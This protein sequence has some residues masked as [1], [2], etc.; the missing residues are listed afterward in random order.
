MR[1][2]QINTEA[3]AGSVGKIAE[4]I[5]KSLLANGDES[6]IAY[7]REARSSKSILIKIGNNL[8]PY[9]HGAYNLLTDKHGF[10]SVSATKKFIKAIG[11]INPDL[12]LLHNLHGYYLNIEI[13]FEYFSIVKKPIV[14]TFHDCWP[15]T[16]HCTHFENINCFKWRTHCESCPKINHY[17][18]SYV[19]NSRFNFSQKKRLFTSLS[20]LTIVTPSNW[21][22]NYTIQSFFKEFVVKT[23]HNGI[24]IDLF[25]PIKQK[26]EKPYVLFVSNRWIY[27]KGYDDIFKLRALIDNEIDFV[28]VGMNA[29]Q[30]KSL[31]AGIKGYKRTRDLNQLVQLY[32]N[33]LCL[34]NPT[35]SDNFPTVNL[36]AL[37]CGTPVITYNT[38]GSPEAID[39]H[40]G[41][42]V[43]KGDVSGIAKAVIEIS[44]CDKIDIS[45]KCRQRAEALFDK[46]NVSLE[47]INLFKNILEKK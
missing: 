20:N 18:K 38:G 10:A 12:I 31:P 27:T 4:E 43:D 1:I 16:G 9:L 11:K 2:L 13:L 8:N 32:S 33:T 40:T 22:N 14:W 17:P 7:G 26:A 39:K 46:K 30:L 15:F 41:F 34:I 47:Y 19:D 44:N 24:D 21:L 29:K 28:V 37:A 3:N 45:K 25:K 6:Y 35:Y 5:G 42:I 23:I 36:E